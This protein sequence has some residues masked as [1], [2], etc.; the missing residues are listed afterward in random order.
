MADALRP[1]SFVGKA[2]FCCSREE[3]GTRTAFCLER[4]PVSGYSL[5]LFERTEA[6]ITKN[7][8]V[9]TIFQCDGCHSQAKTKTRRKPRDSS[10]QR[11]TFTGVTQ[12]LFSKN[13][14]LII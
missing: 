11:F 5:F 10:L 12:P 14:P 8:T 9:V 3:A 4:R 1:A 7:V 13:K 2:I 6:I